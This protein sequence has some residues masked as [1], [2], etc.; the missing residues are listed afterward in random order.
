MCAAIAA[1]VMAVVTPVTMCFTC[2]MNFCCP[3]PALTRAEIDE[4]AADAHQAAADAHQAAADA[5]EAG[6][7]AAADAHEAA[8]DAHALSEVMRSAIKQFCK[9]RRRRR[10]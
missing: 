7:E 6:I 2:I 8:V 1:V 9:C 10:A 5:H 4:A 3:L